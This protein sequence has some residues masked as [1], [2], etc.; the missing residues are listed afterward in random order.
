MN[1]NDVTRK[2]VL[3]ALEFCAL[4]FGTSRYNGGVP[5][6]HFMSKNKMA[7]DSIC[8]GYYKVDKNVIVIFK[9]AHNTCVDLLDTVIHEYTHYLQN[10]HRYAVLSR[11][12]NYYDH[13][14]EIEA[15]DTGLKYKW[16]CKDYITGLA[17]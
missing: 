5:R 9:K 13:P 10:L 1:I 12:Y 3:K 4:K 14:Y 2:E 6:I 8:K 17:S 11:S 7:S 16:D 15:W